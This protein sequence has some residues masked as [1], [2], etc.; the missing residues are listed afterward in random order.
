M[1][2]VEVNLAERSYTIHIGVGL[3]DKLGEILTQIDLPRKVGVFTNPELSDYGERAIGSLKRAGFDPWLALVPSG[4]EHK[5]LQEAS[6]LYGVMLDHGMDRRSALVALGGGMIGDLTG[7][8]AATYM[9]GIPFVQV[10]TTL[11]AQVD[12]S[13]GGKVAVNHPR[14]K[15]LIG[16]FHQPRSVIIDPETLRSLSERDLRSGMAEVIKHSLILDEGFLRLIQENVERIRSLDMDFMEE[17]IAHSCRIK[18]DVVERDERE[19][20]LRMILNFGHT[21]GHAIEAV[22]GYERFRHGEAVSIGMICAGIISLKRGKLSQEEF[23]RIRD[24]L[25]RIGLP[26][27]VP[28][29]LDLREIL[30]II[31]HD[32]KV[33]AGRLNFVLLERIGRAMISDDVTEEEISSAIMEAHG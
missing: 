30:E 22:T 24:L 1:R 2:S 18:A 13:V 8:V 11:L 5:S 17:M 16:A 25:D 10:P 21:V 33:K 7:F 23:K 9:R 4:D 26:I 32:K 20:G 6:E 3:L 29:E 27:Q 12:A 31:R 28:A 19:G 14:A 15:N